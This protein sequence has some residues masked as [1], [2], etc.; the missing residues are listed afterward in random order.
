[1]QLRIDLTDYRPYIQALQDR[2]NADGLY[3]MSMTDAVKIA[4]EKAVEKLLPD[5]EIKKTRKK[6]IKINF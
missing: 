5:V 2:L 6:Y 1:M 3:T 4:I